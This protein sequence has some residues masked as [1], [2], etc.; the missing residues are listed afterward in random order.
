MTSD[1]V[2]YGT[3]E[4]V[5]GHFSVPQRAMVNEH[6]HSRGISSIFSNESGSKAVVVDTSQQCYLLLTVSDSLLPVVGVEG[7]VDGVF[8]DQA[9]PNVFVVHEGQHIKT[10][11][12]LPNAV[13]QAP[14]TQLAQ[15]PLPETH[16]P[17]VLLDGRLVCQIRSSPNLE[18]LLLRHARTGPSGQLA[19][20]CPS[21]PSPPP[22]FSSAPLLPVEG[23]GNSLPSPLVLAPRPRTQNQRPWNLAPYFPHARYPSVPLRAGADPCPPSLPPFRR[24]HNLLAGPASEDLN[25]SDLEA[26]FKQAA[27]LRRLPAAAAA[28]AAASDPAL[29]EQLFSLALE[30]LDMDTAIRAARAMG[31]AGMVL[32]LEVGP[33]GRGTSVSL[34]PSSFLERGR[35]PRLARPRLRPAP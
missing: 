1:F 25:S 11:L 19:P 15:N 7:S 14:V 17:L 26:R 9:D 27:A 30:A 23:W 12:L 2:I 8:W 29:W 13:N 3:T 34:P 31:D 24:T 18:S 4:G 16:V 5:I 35:E 22:L 6:R 21:F 28:A 33:G 32:T 20:S 10:F